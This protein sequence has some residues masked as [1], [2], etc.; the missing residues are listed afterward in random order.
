MSVE[1][2]SIKVHYNWIRVLY[3]YTAL[4]A[5]SAGLLYILARDTFYNMY[6]LPA[7]EPLF[8]GLAAAFCVAIALVCLI[9]LWSPLKFVPVLLLQLFEKLV[10][11]VG[12]I[13]PLVLAN[14]LPSSALPICVVF[15]IALV[16]DV[17]LI[18]WSYLFAGEPGKATN[19][20]VVSG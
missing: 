8:G 14:N 6:A 20:P 2:Q 19:K 15:A 18:P 16:G 12:I 9:G 3:L 17:I 10:W 11:F 7:E 13:F 4:V 1:A 5:G